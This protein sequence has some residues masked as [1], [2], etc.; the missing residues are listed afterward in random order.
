MVKGHTS[1]LHLFENSAS[2]VSQE[3]RHGRLNRLCS[4]EP[5]E[6]RK[7]NRKG[8][9]LIPS[10]AILTHTYTSLGIYFG[11]NHPNSQLPTPSEFFNTYLRDVSIIQGLFKACNKMKNK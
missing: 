6:N 11:K 10:N 7:Y 9:R 8:Q 4:A 5:L 2:I 1:L 3:L